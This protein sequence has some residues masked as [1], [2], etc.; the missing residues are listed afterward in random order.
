M[1]FFLTEYFRLPVAEP[2]FVDLGHNL[3]SV[4][5]GFYVVQL[6][7]SVNAP[8]SVI[9]VRSVL[10]IYAQAIEQGKAYK[11]IAMSVNNGLGD[12][13]WWHDGYVYNQSQANIAF[14]SSGGGDANVGEEK[15]FSGVC[16]VAGRPV[17]RSV[18]AYS[19]GDDP[20]ILASARSDA[21][22]GRYNLTWRGYTG[23]IMITAADD[24]GVEFNSGDAR[25][26]GERIHPA[27]PNGY[28]YEVIS[29]GTLGAEPEWPTTDGATTVSGSVVMTATAFYQ[30]QSQGP[31]VIL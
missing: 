18:I 6:W 23:E 2:V 14:T 16:R 17:S 11:L 9:I 22:T 1:E 31:V 24:Y 7:D 19:L 15:S 3:P 10:R 30:P 8:I 27:T 28:V 13:V 5:S 25:G 12:G 20:R 21:I 29:A 26:S 4:E